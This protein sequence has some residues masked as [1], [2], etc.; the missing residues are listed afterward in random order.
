MWLLLLIIALRWWSLL[1]ITTLLWRRRSLL[2]IRLNVRKNRPTNKRWHIP[3][4][5]KE[6]EGGA[7]M[8]AADKKQLNI[9]VSGHVDSIE[10][11]YKLV[12][13]KRPSV[14]PESKLHLYCKTFRLAFES[15]KYPS[16]HWERHPRTLPWRPRR[17][18]P[19][20]TAH[21]DGHRTWTF[22]MRLPLYGQKGQAPN[23]LI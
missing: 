5:M 21:P 1:V 3:W 19:F 11:A 9:S 2:V 10:S 12:R 4:A 18:G 22:L 7:K 23:W 20:L 13:Q 6:K 16:D 14:S 8:H 15:G 17:L